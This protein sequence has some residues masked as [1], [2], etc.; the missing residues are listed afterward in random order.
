MWTRVPPLLLITA[1]TSVDP[2]AHLRNQYL[3]GT[4]S[5]ID[6]ANEGF[7]HHPLALVSRITTVLHSS[8]ILN[9]GT[10]R[11]DSLPVKEVKVTITI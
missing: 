7:E 5:V 2:V 6:I 8:N 3:F 4:S 10:L 11:D 9:V 1:I